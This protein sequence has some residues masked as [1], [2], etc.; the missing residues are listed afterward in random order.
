MK[1]LIAALIIAPTI[2]LAQGQNCVPHQFVAAYLAEKLGQSPQVMG[3]IA[4]GNI[5]QILGNTETGTWTALVTS[6][7]GVSCVVSSGSDIAVLNAAPQPMG[8]DG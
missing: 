6:P 4:N 3:I 2:A 7:N 8:E 1:Y 5:L